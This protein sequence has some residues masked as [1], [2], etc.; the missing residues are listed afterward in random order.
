M[1]LA[2][3][4]STAR[5]RCCAGRRGFR[6]I[7]PLAAFVLLPLATGSLGEAARANPAPTADF[8]VILP[9]EKPALEVGAPSVLPA[10]KPQQ[11]AESGDDS[12]LPPMEESKPAVLSGAAHIL[13]L[14]SAPRIEAPEPG[15]VQEPVEILDEVMEVGSGDTLIGLL[16]RAGVGASEAY[17]AVN[18]LQDVYSP[19]ALRPGQQI[20]IALQTQENGDGEAETRLA[21]LS[22]RASI[23]QDV[24]LRRDAGG[25]FVAESVARPLARGLDGAA[26]TIRNSLFVDGESLDVPPAVMLKM[27]RALSYAVDF[28][29]DIRGGDRFELIYETLNNKDGSLARSGDLLYASVEVRDRRLEMYRHES[30]DGTVDYFDSDGESLRRLLMR[31]PIDGARLSSGYGMRKHP[32]LGYSRMHRGVDF[33]APT[34]TPIYA[35]GNGVIELAGRNGGYGNYIR[36]RHNGGYKT[37]YAHLNR[38]ASPARRGNRVSQGQVIGY[39]GTTGTSTGAHLHYE[40]MVNGQQVNPRSLDLPT[41]HRLDGEERR[42]FERTMARINKARNELAT[43]IRIAQADEIQPAASQEGSQ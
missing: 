22:L 11:A 38:L 21:G 34:G 41:G 43:E 14:T 5:Q 32:V 33:A 7:F 26:G 17:G 28:Q 4:Q 37:A 35:A 3:S 30:A 9:P 25:G 12:T 2:L 13:S 42:R 16:Q 27:I 6:L 31:T 15:G 8:G 40:V 39:V 29:R 24:R 36:I 23:E 1:R 10:P 19:R 20:E 18:A